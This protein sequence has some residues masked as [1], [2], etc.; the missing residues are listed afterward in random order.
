M[1]THLND[2]HMFCL[3]ISTPPTY[4]RMQCLW[5]STPSSYNHTLLPS[6]SPSSG[7]LEDCIFESL[8]GTQRLN[9]RISGPPRDWT[10]ESPGHLGTEC[11]SLCVT[12]M[13]TE[14]LSPGPLGNWILFCYGLPGTSF[15]A[16]LAPV[17]YAVNTQ[18]IRCQDTAN[19][20]FTGNGQETN[21]YVHPSNQ[22]SSE[23]QANES[24]VADETTYFSNMGPNN[25]PINRSK[26]LAVHV[27]ST[28]ITQ[29]AALKS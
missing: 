27:T 4:N 25:K 17:Q 15:V 8:G 21:E 29:P 7:S 6:S 26:A 10:L 16:N 9:F 20:A 24:P 3:R 5:L 1:F 14:Y 19:N 28:P 11:S 12:C 13:V 23:N 2:N 18:P 22:I